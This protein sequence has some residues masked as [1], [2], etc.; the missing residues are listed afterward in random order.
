MWVTPPPPP[1]TAMADA[2][3]IR[4]ANQKASVAS[5][6]SDGTLGLSPCMRLALAWAV[7]ER[8]EYAGVWVWGFRNPPIPLSWRRA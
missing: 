3:G 4:P 1:L 2:R 7:W 8:E 5:H 6:L